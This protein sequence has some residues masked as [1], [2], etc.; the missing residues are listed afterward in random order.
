LSISACLSKF[1]ATILILQLKI[2]NT[3]SALA[4]VPWDEVLLAPE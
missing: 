4:G 1:R 3:P 2:P